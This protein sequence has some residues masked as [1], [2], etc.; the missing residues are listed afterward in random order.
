MQDELRAFFNEF[1]QNKKISETEIAELNKYNHK[2]MSFF[3]DKFK[4]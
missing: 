1:T 3:V 2:S 4:I